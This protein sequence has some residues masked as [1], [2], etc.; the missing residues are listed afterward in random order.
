MINS[1]NFNI[2][3]FLIQHSDNLSNVMKAV[4]S[5]KVATSWYIY[6]SKL[7]EVVGKD[8]IVAILF[9]GS[10]K[11]NLQSI[12]S[13]S[14]GD[15]YVVIKDGCEEDFFQNLIKRGDIT[16]EIS[17]SRRLF[18]FW[19]KIIN[20]Y[21]PPTVFSMAELNKDSRIVG[22]VKL[23]ILTESQMNSYVSE[24]APDN[25]QI[26]RFSQPMR[27]IFPKEAKSF[28]KASK[29]MC[30][31]HRRSFWLVAPELPETFTT[32][33]YI[34]CYLGLCYGVELRP[35]N[36]S[37]IQQIIASEYSEL[38][39]CFGVMLFELCKATISLEEV[40]LR[41]YEFK[42][43][44]FELAYPRKFDRKSFLRKT[45]IREIIRWI[46]NI[47]TFLDWKVY[48]IGKIERTSNYKIKS[49]PILN[50]LWPITI[51]YYLAKYIVTKHKTFYWFKK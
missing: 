11:S 21:L 46:K 16:T 26:A 37:R 42:L 31:A 41:S 25:H 48:I 49:G 10:H 9:Y 14:L 39:I 28:E 40:D 32:E 38:I 6:I 3:K 2:E 44:E 22:G 15:F 17:T 12:N 36:K 7:A 51:W 45:S 18:T 13:I 33:N 27:L 23:C 30:E 50:K 8:N 5:Q 19:L 24:K 47:T 43:S 35:E 1:N 34:Y 4:L 20:R 29:W